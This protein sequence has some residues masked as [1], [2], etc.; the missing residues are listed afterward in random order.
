MGSTYRTGADPFAPIR[1]MAKWTLQ[2]DPAWS[3]LRIATQT[4][5][6]ILDFDCLR[7]RRA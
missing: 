2:E 3:S 7:D 4:K 6:L 5:L 1:E